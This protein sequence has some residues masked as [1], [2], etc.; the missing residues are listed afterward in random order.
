MLMKATPDH[1]GIRKAILVESRRKGACLRFPTIGLLLLCMLQGTV[2]ADP[3]PLEMDFA[4]AEGD[5]IPELADRLNFQSYVPGT[6]LDIESSDDGM[7]LRVRVP[8]GTG[9]DHQKNLIVQPHYL[10]H[11]TGWFKYED[12]LQWESVV[13]GRL[14]PPTANYYSTKD[15]VFEI[16]GKLAEDTPIYLCVQ[17]NRSAKPV[18]ASLVERRQYLTE[19]VPFSRLI[20]MCYAITFVLALVN[21]VFYFFIREKP[22]LLYSLYML[23]ALNNLVWQEGWIGRLFSLEGT[24]WVERSLHSFAVL[25]AL[26][27]YSFFRSYLGLSTKE[28]SGRFFIGAQVVTGVFL[29]ASLMESIALD[30]YVRHF[31]ISLNNG[32]V[33]V[34][35]LGV[36]VVTLICWIGGNRLAAY[37]FLANL[38]LVSATLMRVYDAF[39][40]GTDSHWLNHSLEVAVAIDA[41]LLSA[42]VADRALSIRR[43]RDKAKVDLEKMDTAYQR[44]QMLA[45]FVRQAKSL[46]ED[47]EGRGFADKLD[48]LMFQSINRMIDARDVVLLSQEGAE[49][50]H[51]SIGEEPVLSHLLPRLF[52]QDLAQMV[53][54]CFRG[55]VVS[56]EIADDPDLQ[57]RY[58]FLL[59]PVRFREPLNYCVVLL[60]PRTQSLDEEVVYGL[61]EFVEKAVHARMDA[62]NMWKLQHSAKFDL[63]TGVLNRATMETHIS[64]VLEQSSETGRGL[65]LAFLDIDHFKL[66]N[67][68]KG[69]DFGDDCLRLLCRTMREILPVDAVIG[70]FGGDEFLVLLPGADYLQASQHLAGLNHSLQ[71]RMSE[72]DVSF[73][74]SV[75]ISECLEGQKMSMT[76]LLKNADRSL[77]AAKAAGKGCIGEKVDSG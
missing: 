57:E 51:R 45:G 64:S 34:G 46:A 10:W 23:L 59:I 56:G 28:W 68:S 36:F 66:L 74:V 48:R 5:F 39:T 2:A 77:Y 71:E 1:K 38:V 58:N 31:W 42:A 37:L 8:R 63:L 11:V 19:D 44:E 13:V 14:L 43:E 35:A 52:E 76:E 26:A 24:V 65:S 22:F 49:F 72:S 7:V 16:E 54:S 12:Q 3:L 67:D 6:P 15:L 53:E 29:V 33:A 32:V 62:E 9:C 21:L 55:K 75:G 41:I 30:T 47:H 73:S 40:F 17:D 70:R 50:K 4:R 25:P 69:H 18:Q 27:Y 60:V 20:A 61:R